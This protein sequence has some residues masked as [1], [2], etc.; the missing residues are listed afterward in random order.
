MDQ[1]KYLKVK[2]ARLEGKTKADA[3]RAAGYAETTSTHKAATNRLLKVVDKE[4]AETLRS[5]VE[6]KLLITKEKILSNL[7]KETE[8]AERSA[9]R[10]SANIAIAKI[11]NYIKD[12]P[13]QSVAVFTG[14]DKESTTFLKTR[15][16]PTTIQEV[17]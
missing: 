13:A 14:L 7:Y 17:K 8:T 15:L 4:L 2:K 16:Q 9:D 5:I 1:V 12:T 10:T 11:C 3:M 6:G